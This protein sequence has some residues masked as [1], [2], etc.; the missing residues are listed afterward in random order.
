M[1]AILATLFFMMICGIFNFCSA[2]NYDDD[3]NYIRASTNAGVSYYIDL[4]TIGV[5]LY[6]PPYYIIAAKITSVRHRPYTENSYYLAKKYDWNKKETF[7]IDR[8]GNWH[9]DEIKD[10]GFVS[11]NSRNFCDSL[12]RAVYNIDF[13]G[14]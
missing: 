2:H 9:K 10:S 7:S 14:Y 6:N 4:R 5:Q 3:P 11:K 8:N 12:F 13:Y 1:K